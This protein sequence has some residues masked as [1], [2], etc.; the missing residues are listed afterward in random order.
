MITNFSQSKKQQSIIPKWI[1]ILAK[2]FGFWPFS[3]TIVDPTSFD[4]NKLNRFWPIFMTIFYIFC[5]YIQIATQFLL[6]NINFSAMEII[7][8]CTIITGNTSALIAC[9]ATVVFRRRHIQSIFRTIHFIDQK[10]NKLFEYYFSEPIFQY[11][12]IR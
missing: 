7:I 2:I 3:L 8:H 6:K 1:L 12:S 9:I 5:V 11:H 10:V 4:L